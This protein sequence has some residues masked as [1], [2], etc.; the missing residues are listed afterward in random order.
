MGGRCM[1]ES[2]IFG[3]SC[4]DDV[5][6][7]EVVFGCDVV[8]RKCW[9]SRIITLCTAFTVVFKLVESWIFSEKRGDC[10]L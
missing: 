2:H 3:A 4:D 7:S 1:L 8:S 5:V 6:V 9:K 10:V